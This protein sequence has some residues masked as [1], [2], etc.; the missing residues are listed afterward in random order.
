MLINFRSYTKLSSWEHD[1]KRSLSFDFLSDEAFW[2]IE[3]LINI[4]FLYHFKHPDIRISRVS[5]NY[6]VSGR[7][8]G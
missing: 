4:L 6:P 1:M 7:I 3:N 5:G 8:A 2:I